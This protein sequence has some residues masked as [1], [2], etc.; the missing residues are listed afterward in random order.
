VEGALMAKFALEISYLK[1]K[2]IGL[3]DGI[4]IA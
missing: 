2:E 1:K 3:I 4:E